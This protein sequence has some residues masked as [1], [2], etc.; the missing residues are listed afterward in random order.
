M[1]SFEANDVTQ[2]TFRFGFALILAMLG[3]CGAGSP[4]TPDL[5]SANEN[6]TA[7]PTT[8]AAE[9]TGTPD[10][11]QSQAENPAP[12]EVPNAPDTDGNDANANPDVASGPIAC[13]PIDLEARLHILDIIN[14]LRA[15]GR[16]CGAEW[17]PAAP[18]LSWNDALDGASL[19]HSVDM[20]THDVFSHTGTDGSSVSDRATDAGYNWN[21]IGENIAAGQTSAEEAIE[22]WIGSPGHCSNIM[23]ANFTNMALAC[24][25]NPNTQFNRYWTQVLGREF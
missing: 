24:S 15:N 5:G 18:A 25:S 13:G 12:S 10:T 11:T 6:T 14:E 23:Q 21:R 19:R 3:A 7:P 9:P 16:N 1:R 17:Y 4:T 22:G 2:P 20:S 8:D